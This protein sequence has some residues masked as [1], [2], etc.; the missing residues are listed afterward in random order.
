MHTYIHT[1]MHTAPCALVHGAVRLG[2]SARLSSIIFY[3]PSELGTVRLE[4]W[5]STAPADHYIIFALGNA[6]RAI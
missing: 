6:R 4:S 1:Y 2:L 5:S 3:S